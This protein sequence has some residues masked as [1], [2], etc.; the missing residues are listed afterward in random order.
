M[1]VTQNTRTG[2]SSGGWRSKG[3]KFIFEFNSYFFNIESCPILL[4]CEF[5]MILRDLALALCYKVCMLRSRHNYITHNSRGLQSWN[6]GS[7]SQS[8]LCDML[9][10]WIYLW[11]VTSLSRLSTL[12]V[13]LSP[14]SFVDIF[15]VPMSLFS[16]SLY[17]F[18]IAFYTLADHH[19]CWVYTLPGN[20]LRI[21][22]CC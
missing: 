17:D 12:R 8:C 14:R 4:T 22:V 6:S 16:S 21:P 10:W 5:W 2:F 1:D 3:L 13:I 19:C 11:K 18:F 20:K 9:E 7:T 15:A